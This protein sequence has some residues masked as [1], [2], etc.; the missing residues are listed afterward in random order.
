MLAHLSRTIHEDLLAVLMNGPL[1]F[2][3]P[4]CGARSRG[5]LPPRVLPGPSE[6]TRPFLLA[7]RV[8]RIVSR[9]P[10]GVLPTGPFAPALP[11]T[12]AP[13]AR[14]VRGDASRCRPDRSGA[15]ALPPCGAGERLGVRMGEDGSRADRDDADLGRCCAEGLGAA[16]AAPVVSDLEDLGR[17]AW[18]RALGQGFDVARPTEANAPIRNPSTSESSLRATPGNGR[19]ESGERTSIWTPSQLREKPPAHASRRTPFSAPPRQRRVRLFPPGGDPFPGLPD[20]EV[21]QQEGAPPAWS[22]WR[23]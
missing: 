12:C 6:H 18:Q 20:R 10:A 22:G 14:A 23:A 5:D 9:V 13:D 21:A 17:E 7:A 2:P 3:P 8:S 16:R 11:P 19:P 4:A 1:P 15:R